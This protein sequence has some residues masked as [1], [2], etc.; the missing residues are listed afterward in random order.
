M[1]ISEKFVI[2]TLL[3]VAK[4]IAKDEWKKEIQELANHIL[5]TSEGK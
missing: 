5:H 4:L 3:L 2:R 1:S